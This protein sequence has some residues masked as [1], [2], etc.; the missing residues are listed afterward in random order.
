MTARPP[1]QHLHT[2]SN[3]ACKVVQGNSGHWTGALTDA[4]R[5]RAEDPVT[6]FRESVSDLIVIFAIPGQ[7]RQQ[8]N[9][10]HAQS[11]H[12]DIDGDVVVTHKFSVARTRRDRRRRHGEY[13]RDQWS[14]QLHH[15][16]PPVQ[17]DAG[18]GYAVLAADL[19]SA[20]CAAARRAIG[21]R[22][23]EQDT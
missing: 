14:N 15:R 11:V 7:R 20:A 23:G 1:P 19:P 21:T 10:L 4:A 13:P 6:D 17:A 18:L 16:I 22:N 12:D 2:L 5:L 9:C 8:N 3:I